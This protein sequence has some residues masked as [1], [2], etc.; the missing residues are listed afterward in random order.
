MAR[1]TKSEIER[2]L[3]AGKPV[4][5]KDT[6]GK[7]CWVTLDD[8][9]QRRLF[10]FLL[11][12]RIREPTGLPEAFI[13]S[14]SNAYEGGNDP[15]GAAVDSATS[16][17]VSG[18]WHLQCIES[19]GFGGLNTWGGPTFHFDFDQESLLLEGPNGSGKSSLVGAVLWALSGERPRDQ[20]HSRAHEAEPV[21]GADDKQTGEWPP[22]ACY[23]A[24]IPELK[25]QPKVRV[26]LKFKDLAGSVAK[27]ERTLVGNKVQVI[28]DPAL[29]IPPI[30]LE[31]GLLMPARLTQLRLKE[32]G[33]R[34]T[35]AVQKLTGLD[36][37]VEIGTLIDGLC[38][39][40]R[41]YLSYARHNNIDET[42]RKFDEA[43][44][45]VRKVLAPVGI[46]VPTFVPADTEDPNGAMAK[47]G[48]D[49]KERAAKLTQV[50][51]NDL[52]ASLNLSDLKTQ[53]QVIVAISGARDDI[54]GGL[55]SLQTW[56]KLDSIVDALAPEAS[57][58][59]SVAIA[60]ARQDLAEA[61]DLYE[62]SKTDSR[63][64]LKAVGARWHAEHSSGP[65]RDCPLC[66]QSLKDIPALAAELDVLRAAGEASGRTFRDNLN[67]ISAGLEVALPPALR[68]V[69]SDFWSLKARDALLEDIRSRFIENP[70]YERCLVKFASIVQHALSQAPESDLLSVAFSPTEGLPE[71]SSQVLKRI[72]TIERVLMF[73]AWFRTEGDAW[74]VWWRKLVEGEPEANKAGSEGTGELQ[75]G[76]KV[77]DRAGREG[78]SAHLS[79]LLEA[80]DAAEPFRAAAEAMRNAWQHGR[81]VT[82]IAREQARRVEI[83]DS[84]E[85]LK[86]LRALA[87]G[88]ARQAID[89]LSGRISA[90]LDSIYL[91]DSFRFHNARLDR[92][93]G[94]VVRGGFVPDLRIDATLVA[95]TSW[96][97]AV[98]WAFLFSLREEA[99][100]Q[101]GKDP[102]P[103]LMFD[104]P[105]TTFD[106]QHRHRWAQYVAALQNGPSNAQVILTTCDE[107]F[108]DL[109]KVDGVT[110]RQALIA[111]AS[112]ELGSV[113]LF[114][115]EAL[116]R[117]WADTL[118]LNTP[119][120]ARD[121]MIAVRI[122]VEGMLKLMLRGED[123][124]LLAFVIGDLREKL[125][126]LHDADIAPWNR[127]EL[128]TLVGALG[129]S[130]PPMKYMEIAHHA[131]GLHLGMSEAVD[132]EKHWRQKLR[133]ALE[134]GFRLTR[135][136]HF[137]H[138]GLKA[139]HAALP[140]VALPEGYQAKVRDISLTVLGRAA[141]L[142][143]GR[144]AD[145]RVDMNLGQS[146]PAKIVLGRHF[147]FRLA[148]PT[149]EPVARVGD[150]LLV[151]E[152]GEPPPKSLVVALSEDH[153]LVRRFEISDNHSD[154]AVLTAQAINPRQIAPPV[155]AQKST[156]KL[157]Q[158]I[159]VLF[160][161]YAN[162]SPA[163]PG[164]EVCDC[165]SEAVVTRL[166]SNTFLVEVVGQSAE[167]IALNGQYLIVK[168]A[169]TAE[170]ALKRLDGKPI[171]AADTNDNLYFKRLR[172]ASKESIVLESLDSGGDY[173]PIVLSPPGQGS[174]RLERVW[175]VVGVLFELPT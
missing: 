80:L 112:P 111:A 174:N 139:L 119:Q 93:E 92:K 140:S 20:A 103:L 91:T 132:V 102:F 34:L 118:R 87:Q 84:L 160:D 130:V 25:S 85:P 147:V 94:V 97:R 122:Y 109:I 10:A 107:T 44:E 89:D 19:E 168:E 124:G 51:S 167:P 90:I 126:Q 75:V 18:P 65:V 30:L 73:A 56:K 175:P 99:V 48:K 128:K 17:S 42:K 127:P 64:Q 150:V 78:L 38:H 57:A 32:G 86:D 166:A 120:A 101:L 2:A 96:L 171:I 113:G 138:G 14:L 169:V 134:R 108:L 61:T 105:Q 24:T 137:L 117:K 114:E 172:M 76:E 33:G 135:T 67:A 39:K 125:R 155:V 173:G 116:D 11:D 106:A 58:L 146:G 98:L 31:T 83:A 136:H 6:N 95:N 29:E 15:A 49:V 110:G 82:K 79:R 69:S 129:K 148:A 88:M 163:A 7:D 8:S 164:M 161:N 143:D 55:A 62:R 45:S 81:A 23:P 63:F 43:V 157:H 47:F 133:P 123:S 154:V 3:L 36:E 159:G 26:E 27:V 70:R 115:G 149:L 131:S 21:Y 152:F 165:G 100:E 1:L 151:K 37:L 71:G 4:K 145:G 104:D 68:T 35:D 77:D 50:I 9:K 53:Q 74:I 22:V 54:S 158:V 72:A 170:A 121:Y 66:D 41:E 141:A 13:A 16:A 46:A 59:L 28:K 162:G 12:S 40:N 5:W 142:T 52:A 153:I 60:K 144:A 156:L